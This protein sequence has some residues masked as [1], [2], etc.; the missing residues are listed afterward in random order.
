MRI[1]AL[2]R[3]RDH[4]CCRYRLRAFEPAL[5]AAGHTIEYYPFDSS[6]LVRT[7]AWRALA[8][9]DLVILQRK[10]LPVWQQFM[11]RR[12]ARFLIFDMDDAVFL[13]DSYAPRGLYSS[14]RW[15]RFR[16][17]VRYADAVTTGNSFLAS[18]AQ[19]AGAR[20]VETIPTCVDPAR[21]RLASHA[22]DKGEVQL[23]WIGTSSTLVGLERISPVL[24]QL[25]QMELGLSLKLI[26]N[27][28]FHL[29]HMAV[30][31][32]PW[33]EQTEAGDLADADIGVSWI[34]DDDWSRG[35]C[36][37]KLLQYMAAGLPVVAN[38]VGVQKSIVVDGETGFLAATEQE[39]IQ[40]V[41]RLAQDRRLRQRM[42]LAGR[43][44]AES[45]YGLGAGISSWLD[46]L[47]H[48]HR[49]KQ[50]A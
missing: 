31:P 36:G 1:L 50:A 29:R 44:R 41:S 34:P 46:V 45:L 4:V 48:F 13:R 43:R 10:L 27:R 20:H 8:Q 7:S 33:S 16:A 42:G 9:A 18:E 28:F 12:S 35:K 2:V 23:V 30:L 22:R 3:D 37:L 47:D 11:L 17:Q 39:W 15:L 21:Y 19:F 24:D 49:S 14:G 32:C 40:A 5:T 38:P 6:W 26:S 25:G